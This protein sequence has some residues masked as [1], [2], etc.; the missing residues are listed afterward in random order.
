MKGIKV[1]VIVPVYN[2]EKYLRRCLESIIKQTLKELEIIVIND[3]SK[4]KSLNIIEEYSKKDTRI[5]LINQKNMGSG[6]A[7]N[8]GII[9]AKGEYIC[10]VDSDDTIEN[11]M[12]KE[13]YSSSRINM[14]DIVISRYQK[15]DFD[16]ILLSVEKNYE[17]Y[18]SRKYFESLISFSLPSIMCGKLYKR[19]LFKESS[20]LFPS[21]NMHNEDTSTLYKIIFFASKISF[22][23]K[24]FYNWYQITNS[25]TNSTSKKQLEDLFI[26][27]SKMKI[28]FIK[29]KI[30]DEFRINLINGYFTG[31]EQRYKR[32]IKYS[33][34]LKEEKELI[35]VLSLLIIKD[36][37]FCKKNIL[38][39]K[40]KNKNLYYKILFKF[41]INFRTLNITFF[42]KLFLKEDCITI[43]NN[44]KSEFGLIQNIF[45]ELKNNNYK[46]IYIYGAGEICIQTINYLKKEYKIMG[47][48][49]QNAD[50]IKNFINMYSLD[51]LENSLEDVNKNI[52]I[53]VL[54]VAFCDEITSYINSYARK[55]NKQIVILNFYNKLL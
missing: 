10:F 35:K 32:I 9:Q 33:S 37:F 39:F 36:T 25:K 12:L 6:Q 1:S 24:V 50:K 28:F 34:S 51:T 16:G 40:N 27:Y 14:S 7:K 11:I 42:E 19:E 17:T 55:K 22:V 45:D 54:S 30:L 41:F 29:Y 3:G 8:N 2:S 48:I 53:I 18:T 13:M 15:L 52:T 4:D 46:E 20:L 5:K 26:V 23:N 47:I 49:D 43:L 38:L 44:H 21:T 31:I